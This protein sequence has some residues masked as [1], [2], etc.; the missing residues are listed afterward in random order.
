M[1]IRLLKILAWS[2]G[3]YGLALLFSPGWPLAIIYIAA[4]WYVI[5]RFSVR[6]NGEKPMDKI[7]RFLAENKD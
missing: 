4:W 7:K 6:E 2:W 5:N 3:I 1:W